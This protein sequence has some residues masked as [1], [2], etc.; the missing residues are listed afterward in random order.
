MSALKILIEAAVIG[1]MTLLLGMTIHNFLPQKKLTLALFITGVL[2][3]LGFEVTGLNHWYC[4][5][6]NPSVLKIINV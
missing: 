3:H 4:K 6:Y 5:G 2:I 1:L